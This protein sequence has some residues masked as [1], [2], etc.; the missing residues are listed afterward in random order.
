MTTTPRRKWDKQG[1]SQVLASRHRRVWVD[2][3]MER[4]RQANSRILDVTMG[5]MAAGLLRTLPENFGV[6][7]MVAPLLQRQLPERASLRSVR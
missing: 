2:C 6:N 1:E 4:D 7:L 5:V 3:R